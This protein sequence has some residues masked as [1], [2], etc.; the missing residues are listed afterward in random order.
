MGRGGR[1]R[2]S[3]RGREVVWD[4]FN[5]M[6]KLTRAGG[7]KE[8]N[9]EEGSAGTKILAAFASHFPRYKRGEKF[10]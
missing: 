5:S 4:P 3:V 7:R 8:R 6:P 1:G 10:S 9:R 2:T